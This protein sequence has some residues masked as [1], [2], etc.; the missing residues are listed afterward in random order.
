[1]ISYKLN[2]IVHTFFGRGR[3]LAHF[4]Q[5]KVCEVFP[6]CTYW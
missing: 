2:Y 3:G 6:R 5:H 4:A 1:M